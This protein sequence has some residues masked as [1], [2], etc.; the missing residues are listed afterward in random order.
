MSGGG[1]K[2]IT[3]QRKKC[4]KKERREKI[5]KRGR[6]IQRQKERQRQNYTDV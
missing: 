1:D 4:G 6:C 5:K 2:G 3:K